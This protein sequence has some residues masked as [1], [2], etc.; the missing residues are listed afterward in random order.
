VRPPGRVSK[1]SPY[2]PLRSARSTRR[3]GPTRGARAARI[4]PAS[5]PQSG[6]DVMGGSQFD[7]PC[8][9]DTALEVIVN[10]P[11]VRE[12]DVIELVELINL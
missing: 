8:R 11:N 12:T 7:I 1:P 10:Y 9:F 6:E 2:G 3:S 5:R 4:S